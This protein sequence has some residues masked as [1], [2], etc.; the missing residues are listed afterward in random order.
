M[1]ISLTL[2]DYN[3]VINTD[4]YKEKC[5][6]PYSIL[7]FGAVLE[8][9]EWAEKHSY[10]EGIDI[11]FERGGR[12]SREIHEGIIKGQKNPRFR[13][14]LHLGG[15]SFGGKEDMLPLQAADILAHQSWCFLRQPSELKRKWFELLLRHP[16]GEA[17]IIDKEFLRWMV[18]VMDEKYSK[19]Q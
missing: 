11:V 3:E 13:E 18:G 9:A 1:I 14:F 5:G 7:A 17:K 6:R 2:S 12:H 8:I 19:S 15:F 4:W 16:N 10:K